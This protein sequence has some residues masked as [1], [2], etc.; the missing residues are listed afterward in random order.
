MNNR[1]IG[2]K[3]N[4]GNGDKNAPKQLIISHTL[5]RLSPCVSIMGKIGLIVSN[6]IVT[7]SKATD[8]A[9]FTLMPKGSLGI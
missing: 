5:L 9:N 2:L 4:L 7:V 6:G 1:Q 8:A 3:G